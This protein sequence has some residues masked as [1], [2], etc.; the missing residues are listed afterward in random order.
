ML[1]SG[2]LILQYY[3]H[4]KMSEMRYLV[5]MRYEFEKEWFSPYL[6]KLYTI[7]LEIGLILCLLIV[8]FS[9]LVTVNNISLS[10]LQKN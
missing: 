10:F 3:A 7:A 4:K 5:F 6:M 2:A 1:L 8:I 9:I